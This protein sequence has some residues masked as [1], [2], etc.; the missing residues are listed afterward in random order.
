MFPVFNGFFGAAAD[1]GHAMGTMVFLY[2]S[3]V[4]QMDILKRT[5]GCAFSAGN[6]AGCGIKF[7]CVDEHRVKKDVYYAAV[8]SVAESKGR[9]W[10]W[11]VS[12]YAGGRL[13][14]HVFCLP[15]EL[16]CF[17]FCGGRKQ[18]NIVFRHCDPDTAAVVHPFLGT[19]FF[20]I[21]SGVS[22]TSA[23]CHDKINI[24]AA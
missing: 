15:N 5:D 11:C 23:A 7:L 14:N 3:A 2:R 18:C 6:T 21:F 19:E 20:E 1:T 9:L 17:F 16:Q 4:F 24:L 8:Y 12:F 22:H 13:I 10:K